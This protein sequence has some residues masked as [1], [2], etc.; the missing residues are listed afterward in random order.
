M[1]ERMPAGDEPCDEEGDRGWE[2]G[3]M[4]DTT[5]TK[6]LAGWV[7][8]TLNAPGSPGREH[9]FQVHPLFRIPGAGRVD[10]LTVRHETGGL[11]RFRI[12][13]W[14]ILPRALEDKDVDAM[15]RRLHAFEAW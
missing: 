2:D 3:A 11:D 5:L 8:S 12:D 1:K 7:G 15:M 13:L 14:T 4:S 10:L 6:S 9:C